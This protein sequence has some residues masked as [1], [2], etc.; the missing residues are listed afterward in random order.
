MSMHEIEDLVEGSVRVLDARCPAGDPRA[1][2]WFGTLYRFQ[3]GFDCSFTR[4]RVMDALLERRFTYR[5]PVERHPDYA[6]RRGYFDGLGEFTALAEIDEDDEEFEGFEDWLDDG[7]VEPPFLYCDA[8]TGLWRRMVEAGTLGGAD[9]EPPRRTPLAEVAH[10]VAAAAEQE[11]DHE[12]IA[13]W[14]A[15]GWSALTGDLVVFDP[16]DHPD[17]CGLREIARRTGALS[18]DLPHGVRPPAEVFEGDEL[19]AWWWADA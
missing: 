6:A 12:L 18:I 9:A 10:A 14:H 13:M 19:E 4:F 7:Y 2:D 16:R 3:E 8:G 1:R 17:L 11:G 15:L 5:F